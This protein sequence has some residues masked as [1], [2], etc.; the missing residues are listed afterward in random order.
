MIMSVEFFNNGNV[1][2]MVIVHKLNCQLVI[3]SESAI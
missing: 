1:I 2:F 3:D